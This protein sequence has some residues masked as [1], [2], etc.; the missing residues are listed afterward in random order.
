M[1][2]LLSILFSISISTPN[3][4]VGTLP[5]LY[6]CTPNNCR[7]F[8][9]AFV[10]TLF[11]SAIFPPR[12]LAVIKQ[13]KCFDLQR[14]L[15]GNIGEKLGEIEWERDEVDINILVLLPSVLIV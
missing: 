1:P 9:N 10:F 4:I 6:I 12:M 7:Y 14:G 3:N 2:K 8:A 11:T 15:Q 13:V 5:A